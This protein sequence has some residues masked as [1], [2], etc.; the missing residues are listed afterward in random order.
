MGRV[1][2]E[3]IS[4]NR[5]YQDV[6]LLLDRDDVLNSIKTLKHEITR[7]ESN[8][9]TLGGFLRSYPQIRQ[10]ANKIL[11]KYRYPPGFSDVILSAASTNKITDKDVRNCYFSFQIDRVLD[12]D[13]PPLSTPRDAIL[14]TMYP[15]LLRRRKKN[16]MNE[17]SKLLVSVNQ[18]LIHLPSQHPLMIDTRPKIRLERDWYWKNKN[19]IPT[20]I[21][22]EEY[23]K[24]MTD[25]KNFIN[26]VNRVD[27]AI[28]DYRKLL[29]TVF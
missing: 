19:K 16:I 28:S 21:I 4:D 17:I 13:L 24:T 23:N 11:E 1:D 20:N 9:K 29:K 25:E 2:L 27:Q 7:I 26:D 5:I 6:A 22:V 18:Y 10:K 12:K 8:N 14:I 15:Y 3:A